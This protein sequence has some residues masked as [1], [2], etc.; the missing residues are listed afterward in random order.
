MNS[1][2][3]T[4]KQFAKQAGVTTQYVY[5]QIRDGKLDKYV[6]IVDGKRLL[7]P[8]AL[9]K[10]SKHEHVNETSTSEQTIVL[11]LQDQLKE[12]DKQIAD[13]QEMLKQS[14]ELLK[15]EQ[16]IRYI[17]ERRILAIEGQNAA[18]AEETTTE[19]EEAVTGEIRTATEPIR[20]DPDQPEE[21]KQH[22]TTD[23]AVVTRHSGI[24]QRIW[25]GI[26]G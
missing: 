6:E 25:K 12:K 23:S 20:T 22:N 26:R 17:T 8:E 19:T 3:M 13:L 4:V 14:Q 11:F 16:N 1:E 21:L 2:Y 10:F 15:V 24:L 9:N 7:N 18:G 5:K